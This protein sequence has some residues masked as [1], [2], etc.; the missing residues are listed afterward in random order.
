MR[1]K[2]K[3]SFVKEHYYF[4]IGRIYIYMNN[5]LIENNAGVKVVKRVSLI[6][7]CL[8][9]MIRFRWFVTEKQVRNCNMS[10]HRVDG[11]AS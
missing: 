7:S 9:K 8:W 2:L 5:P 10:C 6:F 3:L 11:L 1:K 4:I